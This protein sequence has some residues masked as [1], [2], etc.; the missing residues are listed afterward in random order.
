MTVAALALALAVLLRAGPQ[1]A[2]RRAGCADRA[3]GSLVGAAGPRP[4]SDPL[5]GAAALDIFAVCLNAGMAVS[6]AARASA[7]AAPPAL[8]A[9]LRRAADLLA[10]GA[11]P[12][13]AWSMPDDSPSAPDEQHL[14]LLRLARRSAASGAALA[15]G[16]TEL[17]TTAR[18]RAGHAANAAAERA[19]VVIAGPLGVCFLPAFVCLGVL[20]VVAGLASKVF[21]SGLL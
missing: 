11:D 4:D 10:L 16:V 7:P 19:S 17:A 14:A 9:L 5:A 3:T 1:I 6:A 20:P 13:K 8:S 21:G 12:T 18:T 15:D 2:R